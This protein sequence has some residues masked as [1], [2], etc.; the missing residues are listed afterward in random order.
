MLEP[1]FTPY[2]N[3]SKAFATIAA[4]HCLLKSRSCD[5]FERHFIA[6][7]FITSV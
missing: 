6:R 7:Y 1:F 2:S 3:C 4:S 5:L